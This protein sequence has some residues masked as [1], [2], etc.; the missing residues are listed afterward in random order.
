MLVKLQIPPG[1][2]SNGTDY[3]SQGRWHDASLV[4]WRSGAMEPIGGWLELTPNKVTGRPS[5]VHQYRSGADR[6][7]VV[8][9]HS[10]LWYVAPNG[11]LT[12]ITPAGYTGGR[13]SRGNQFGYGLGTYGTSA[14]G[15]SSHGTAAV[16]PPTNWTLDN[17]GTF[18]VASANTDGTLYY[19]DGSTPTATVMAG[20]PVNNNA[21]IVSEERFVFALGAG[22]N[23]ALVQWSDQE[24]FMV[25]T[26]SSTNQAGDFTL[27]TSGA[28]LCGL[29]IRG[30]L[31]ILTTV[32]AHTAS[33]Q[34]A[35]Y[36]YGF[37]RVGNGCG[38]IGPQAATATDSFAAWMGR[39]GFFMFDGYVKPLPC[40]VFD[41]VY[42]DI[43]MVQAEKVAAWNNTLAGEIWWLYP[44][45]DTAE[46][47]RY[48]AWNYRENTW[49]IGAIDR[50]CGSDEGVYDNPIMVSSDGTIY[51]H[52]IGYNYDG[53]IPFAESG[54]VELGNGDAV[55]MAK[56]L[57]PDEKTQGDVSA[58][59]KTRF[60]PNG[61]ES[62]HGPYSMAA[63]TSVRFTGRQVS[64]RIESARNTDWRFGIPRLDVTPGGTR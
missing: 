33:Y 25:W 38:V 31:L 19:W 40:D 2:Y 9:T 44:S 22:G 17:F 51:S 63:P 56:H 30:Q 45:A 7:L 24:D 32:D 4:R 49:A 10:A 26:P 28:I 20:A 14:F 60:Y 42:S 57:Y 35:P 16:Q 13:E 1:V 23:D 59:F 47:N 3:Q 62:T 21:S 37:E 12:D 39:D 18:L 54:P 48:I 50:T 55:Y 29:R 11:T 6:K 5:D 43:N 52:E 27:Q 36:V 15:I 64:M 34:G 46:C 53:Q 8:G 41:R 61:P 58:T